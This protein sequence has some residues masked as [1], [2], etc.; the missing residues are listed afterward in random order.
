MLEEMSKQNYIL[1]HANE[2]NMRGGEKLLR[3]FQ[4]KASFSRINFIEELPKRPCGINLKWAY[5]VGTLGNAG[6]SKV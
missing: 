2:R 6:S 4:I 1:V 5:V 3:K